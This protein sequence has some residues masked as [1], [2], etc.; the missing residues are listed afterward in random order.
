MTD[1]QKSE[2]TFER[3]LDG[4]LC[5]YIFTA[6]AALVGVCLTVIGIFRVTTELKSVS[7]IGDNLL[8][9]D[10]LG[11]LSSC[12]LSYIALRTRRLGRKRAVERIA[13]GIFLISLSLMA[14]ICGMIAYEFI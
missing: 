6:S 1:E 3:E 9:I 8:A 11:F 5:I 7:T 12:I 14:V 13:D 4:N 2:Q 10:A